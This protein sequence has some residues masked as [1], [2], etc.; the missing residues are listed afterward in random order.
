MKIKGE[1]IK[2]IIAPMI[3]LLLAILTA[4]S[5]KGPIMWTGL[6]LIFLL[7]IVNL[8]FIIIETN[9][10]KKSV[11]SSNIIINTE[12]EIKMLY[13][14]L[15]T[16][17]KVL[18]K[19]ENKSINKLKEYNY[20]NIIKAIKGKKSN[21]IK[22]NFSYNI[23]NNSKLNKAR[24][25][26]NL[27]IDK[28]ESLKR[29]FLQLD[30]HKLRI[31]FGKYILKRGNDRQIISSLIDYIGWSYI[32]L[33]DY[34]KGINS[35]NK[36]LEIIENKLNNNDSDYIFYLESK[37][38]A[39]RH[40]GSTYYTYNDE[41]NPKKDLVE[42]LSILSNN[43]YFKSI[44]NTEKYLR[45]EIGIKNNLLLFEFYDY[46]KKEKQSKNDC[47]KNLKNI[48]NKMNKLIDE[49]KFLKEKHRIIKLLTL[50]N[51]IINEEIR[52]NDYSNIELYNKNLKTITD[53]FN[54]NIYFDD[55]METFFE[56]S[57]MSLNYSI[58]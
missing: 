40:K 39:L 56:Q 18:K 6:G 9:K 3:S 44:R 32:L 28:F 5:D 49:S 25:N 31:K 27:I 13:K 52:S 36:A 1:D 23:T 29:I 43:S 24:N 22:D 34:K 55:A 12:K 19:Y 20:K 48:E 10:N 53:L 33:G 45:L 38:R 15:K 35:L 2:N 17:D 41:H 37:V 50:Q 58:K 46:L 47:F 30:Q 4:L 7:F 54:E 42:A 14:L 26:C 57:I 51:L 8:I 21:K 16:N 11:L